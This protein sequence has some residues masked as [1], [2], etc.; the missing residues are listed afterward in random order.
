MRRDDLLSVPLSLIV[1]LGGVSAE[2]LEEVGVVGSSRVVL[3]ILLWPESD[4]SERFERSERSE[5]PRAWVAFTSFSRNARAINIA[6]Y[7]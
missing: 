3:E 5:P 7:V 2:V 4:G 1:I 6:G